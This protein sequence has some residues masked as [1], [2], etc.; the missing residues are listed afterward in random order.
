MNVLIGKVGNFEKLTN[1]SLFFFIKS[2]SKKYDPVCVLWQE[3]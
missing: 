2:R 3:G 1:I